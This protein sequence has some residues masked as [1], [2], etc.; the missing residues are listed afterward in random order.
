MHHKVG[1]KEEIQDWVK[2]LD[3]DSEKK[4]LCT[5]KVF[6][7]RRSV[8]QNNNLWAWMTALANHIGDD[9]ALFRPPAHHQGGNPHRLLS[10]F[11]GPEGILPNIIPRLYQ[12]YKGRGRR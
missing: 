3:L 7:K 12:L 6:R 5:V 10:P 11:D 4:Y 8:S 9:T 1:S 2:T